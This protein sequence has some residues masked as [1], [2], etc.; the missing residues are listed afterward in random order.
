MKK[1]PT[2]TVEDM[3]AHVFGGRLNVRLAPTS[4]AKADIS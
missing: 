2:S 1:K 3:R 4:G